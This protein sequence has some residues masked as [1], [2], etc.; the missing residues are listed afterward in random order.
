MNKVILVILCAVALT[1]CNS[2]APA[3]K[4]TTEKTAKI[5]LKTADLATSKDLVCGMDLTDDL[6]EDTTSYEGKIYGFCN[7]GCKDEFLKNPT[8]YLTQK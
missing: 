6:I 7:T 4:N 3:E 2:H 1:S 5:S 8:S